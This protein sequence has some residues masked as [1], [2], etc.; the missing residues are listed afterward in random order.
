LNVTRIINRMRSDRKNRTAQPHCVDRC[1][2]INEYLD[3]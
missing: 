2:V 1:N 3:F